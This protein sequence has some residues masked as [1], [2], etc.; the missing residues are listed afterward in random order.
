MEVFLELMALVAVV[1]ELDGLLERDSDE[2]TDDDSDDVDEEVAPCI[3]GVVR[4]VDESPVGQ[5][6]GLFLRFRL[7]LKQ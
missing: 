5:R 2:Q 4:R 3:G 1:D 7:M 6:A